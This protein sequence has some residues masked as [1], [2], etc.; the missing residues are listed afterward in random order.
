MINKLQPHVKDRVYSVFYLLTLDTPTKYHQQQSEEYKVSK[1]FHLFLFKRRKILLSKKY[2]EISLAGQPTLHGKRSGLVNCLYQLCNGKFL[3]PNQIAV[4]NH[5]IS[6][7]QK[8]ACVKSER[9][10]Q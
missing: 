1:T 5:M 7:Q 8:I 3:L 9:L 4:S 2:I 10:V 6:S